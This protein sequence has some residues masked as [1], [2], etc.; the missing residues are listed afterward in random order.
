MSAELTFPAGLPLRSWLDS[1]SP[2][3]TERRTTSCD[4]ARDLIAHGQYAH[5]RLDGLR[6]AGRI[7]EM[8]RTDLGLACAMLHHSQAVVML[9]AAG[10]G[11]MVNGTLLWG[12]P[13]PGLRAED[14]A[15]RTLHGRVSACCAPPA[16][17]A[18][19]VV[20][21]HKRGHL[22]TVD[23]VGDQPVGASRSHGASSSTA[24]A[25]VELDGAQAVPRGRLSPD[26]LAHCVVYGRLLEAAA[27][28]GALTR[29]CDGTLATPH[30]GHGDEHATTH[31]AETDAVLSATWG[32]IRDAVSVW[33]RGASSLRT[34][35]HHAA[36][37]RTLTRLAAS[38]VV[39]GYVPVED[40]ASRHGGPAPALRESLVA[41]MARSDLDADARVVAD[42]VRTDGPSW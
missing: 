35:R 42:A 2:L 11:Q 25:S 32:A 7:A 22:L 33:E 36:R 34:A 24:P 37:A 23:L 3:I 9:Q 26:S 27:W 29:L 18:I 13:G 40:A 28:Y 30:S 6:E 4:L 5:S 14:A 39:F 8:A 31:L 12:L 17:D 21:D 15:P 41:W 19:Y 10:A 38:S 20:V 16:G 1:V